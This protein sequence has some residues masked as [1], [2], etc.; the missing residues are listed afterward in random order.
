[1]YELQGQTIGEDRKGNVGYPT[2]FVHEDN[3]SLDAQERLAETLHESLDTTTLRRIGA[4]ATHGLVEI[5]NS[6]TPQET[7]NN[8]AEVQAPEANEYDRL[9][10]VSDDD[11]DRSVEGAAVR[12]EKSLEEIRKQEDMNVWNGNIRDYE[13]GKQ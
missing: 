10:D 7:A 12:P 11:T 5:P 13:N 3:L 9:F 6:P 1:M 4:S 8:A 2:K